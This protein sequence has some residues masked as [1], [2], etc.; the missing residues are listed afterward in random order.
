V[1]LNLTSLSSPYEFPP[2]FNASY[3]N[4]TYPEGYYIVPLYLKSDFLREN[5]GWTNFLGFDI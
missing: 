1:L 4:S 3:P 2:P 5:L